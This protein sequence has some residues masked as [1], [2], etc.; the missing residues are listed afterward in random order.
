MPQG[1]EAVIA[2][3]HLNKMGVSARNAL[4]GA[5]PK[6]EHRKQR[7]RRNSAR[8]GL[9]PETPITAH[10]CIRRSE[11]TGIYPRYYRMLSRR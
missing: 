1:V 4:T 9:T 5:G 3:T 8:H 11:G 7:Y 6:G 2:M 10:R